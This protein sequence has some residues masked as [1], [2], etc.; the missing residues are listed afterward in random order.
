MWIWVSVG[1]HRRPTR[2]HRS[3]A[4]IALIL[5]TAKHTNSRYHHS[6][7]NYMNVIFAQMSMIVKM[8]I[9][10]YQNF[11]SIILGSTLNLFF[12]L[13]SISIDRYL[14]SLVM[15]HLL[16]DFSYTVITWYLQ[17]SVINEVTDQQETLRVTRDT[18]S[19]LCLTLLTLPLAV[20]FLLTGWHSQWCFNYLNSHLL[21]IKP[22]SFKSRDELIL[23]SRLA[24]SEVSVQAMRL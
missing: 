23:S 24:S 13:F 14:F 7:M 10:I 12:S 9:F 4:W 19:I 22:V 20:D 15:K 8:N 2:T 1:Y 11:L 6:A 21:L 3:N 18:R 5:G 17:I 16:Y